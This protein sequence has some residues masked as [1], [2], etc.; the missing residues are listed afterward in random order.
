M[1]K[2]VLITISRLR[3][4]CLQFRISV[5]KHKLVVLLTNI[6]LVVYRNTL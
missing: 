5:Y 1:V 2:G 4:Y 3:F 6:N